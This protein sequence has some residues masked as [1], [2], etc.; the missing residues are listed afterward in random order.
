M[1]PMAWVVL[2]LIG[3]IIL[4][5]LEFFVPSAGMVGGLAACCLVAAI[6]VAY[7]VSVPAGTIVLFVVLAV[8]PVT[9]A[10]MIRVWPYTPIGRRLFL[11]PPS[12]DKSQPYADSES[13]L[14]DLIGQQGIATT[15]MLPAGM[16]RIDKR[17]YD[18]V[19]EGEGV[20][21]GQPVMVRAVKMNRLVVRLHQ[22]LV[23]TPSVT[24]PAEVLSQPIEDFGW[25]ELDDLDVDDT[26]DA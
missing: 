19:A 23:T 22:P 6:V 9:L 8:V 18:A 2:L 10:M 14:K 15:K 4:L 3:G 11:S 21:V 12:S 7:T 5:I 25:D 16:V 17:Q 20:E 13:Q 1:G 24:E 26:K